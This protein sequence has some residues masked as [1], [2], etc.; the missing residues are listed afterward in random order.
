MNKN[1]FIGLFSLLILPKISYSANIYT[2]YVGIDG[3]YN[4]A[5]TMSRHTEYGGLNLNV[6]T[7]YNDYF[8]T[9]IFYQSTFPRHFY[10]DN[11]KYKTSY[12]AYGLDL[13]AYTPSLKG[14][15]LTAS[16]GAATYVLKEKKLGL[17]SSLDE[18]YGY[19]FGAGFIYDVNR[20]ISLRVMARFINFDHISN[21]DH[22]S[23]YSVGLRYN[24]TKE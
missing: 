7:S 2:P 10:L 9:E 1:L 24:F 20:H 14:L 16:L 15:K 3:L 19:R 13:Y 4:K 17:S 21:M 6:G 5:K 11:M 12:R 22:M 18:G 23:E 8:G